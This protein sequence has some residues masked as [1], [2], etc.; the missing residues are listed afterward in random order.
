[1]PPTDTCRILRAS[2]AG[3]WTLCAFNNHGVVIVR[4]YAAETDP[5][6]V[7]KIDFLI[8][9]QPWDTG[10]GHTELAWVFAPNDQAAYRAYRAD[11]WQRHPRGRAKVAV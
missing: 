1:M 7:P 3:Y 11:Y 8:G 2:D 10:W 5:N 6:V 9:A 4:F